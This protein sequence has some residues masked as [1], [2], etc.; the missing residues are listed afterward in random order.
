M[1]IAIVTGASSGLGAAYAERLASRGGLDEVW[2]VA[3]REGRLRQVAAGLPVPARVI[4]LDLADPASER[5]LAHL[6]AEAAGDGG[7]EMAALVCAAGFA[8]FASTPYIDLADQDRMVDVNC[9]ALAGVTR[10][11]LPYLARGAQVLEVSSCAS[12]QP[13]PGLNAYAASK[14]FVRS[15][16]RALR[17]ELRGRHVHVS[18]VCPWWIRTEFEQ[19]ARRTAGQ[20]PTTVGHVTGLAHTPGAVASWSLALNRAGF[21]VITCGPIAFLMRVAGK[22]LPSCV[23]MGIWEGLRRI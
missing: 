19:V 4:P 6:L 18:A 15:F 7:V 16:A 13:L 2:L 14:A 9:R 10:V 5:Q 17:W 21:A 23:T 11:C 20:A 12:F 22:L 1:R 3:R 8:T